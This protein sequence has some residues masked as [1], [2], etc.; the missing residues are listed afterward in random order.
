LTIVAN[1]IFLFDET[2][3]QILVFSRLIFTQF[4]YERSLTIPSLSLFLGQ[5]DLPNC[6]TFC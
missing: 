6:M 3:R 5:Y 2:L 4:E 1:Q